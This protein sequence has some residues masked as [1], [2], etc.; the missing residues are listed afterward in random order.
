MNKIAE[1]AAAKRQRVIEAAALVF[2]RH[3]FAQ[4]SMDNIA[5]AAGSC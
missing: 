3:G 2:R 4:T 1:R 5:V